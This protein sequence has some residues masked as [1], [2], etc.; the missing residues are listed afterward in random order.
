MVNPS[1]AA[2]NSAYEW[3]MSTSNS[4]YH[5]SLEQSKANSYYLYIAWSGSSDALFLATV[6]IG[7]SSISPVET[8]MTLSYSASPSSYFLRTHFFER[9]SVVWGFSRS[10]SSESGA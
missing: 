5:I 7:G 9:N 3:K 4:A 1:T 10:S 8:V 2:I 6:N